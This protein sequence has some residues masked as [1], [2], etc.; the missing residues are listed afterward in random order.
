M[1]PNLF[2]TESGFVEDSFFMD[3]GWEEWF[4]GDLVSYIGAHLLLCG[5]GP[6]RLQ[7]PTAWS[8]GILGLDYCVLYS[9]YFIINGIYF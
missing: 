6:N 7:S 1:V 4:R 3:K 8:L 2:G 5:P 9:G